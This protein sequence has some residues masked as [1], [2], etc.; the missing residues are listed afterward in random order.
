MEILKKI[1]QKKKKLVIGLMSGTSIDG[2]DAVL[3]E[4]LDSGVATK[5]RQLA[6]E[7]YPYPRRFKELLLKSSDIHT[8]RLDD[9]TRLNILTGTLFA[10]AACRI[11]RR[12]GKK[13][14]EID[15]IGSHGQTICH[16]PVNKKLYGRNI[17]GTMQVGHPTIIAKLTGVVTV[18]DYRVGD[19]AVGG[20]GAPLVPYFDY[21]MFR[22]EHCNRGLL[23]IGGIANITVLPKGCN[24]EAVFA[25]DTGP[26]NMVIDGLM[27]KLFGS[28]FDKDGNVASS[29]KIIPSLLAWMSSHPYLKRKPPK[30]T[31]R[32]MFGETFIQQILR[33]LSRHSKRDIVTTASEFTVLSVYQHYLRFVLPKVQLDEILVSGGGV[34]NRY[35]MAALQRYFHNVRI[36]PLEETGFSSD[37]KEAVCFA[38]LANE[39]I[40][41]NPSNIPNATGAH[42]QTVLGVIALP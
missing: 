6:F 21:L 25:F 24:A 19:I 27:G 15:L 28:S 35:F 14:D 10:E 17:R 22:T 42:S 37:A 1:L 34:H 9:L 40:A 36:K 23:N 16:L 38:V 13:M 11:T 26:G 30:S 18:G 41:G 4:V 32:E 12:A 31:G 8:A 5:I 29:G 39:A 3:V 7:T 20:M 2:I 33:R